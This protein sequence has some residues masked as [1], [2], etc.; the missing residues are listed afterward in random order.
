AGGSHR[1]A[2]G[3]ERGLRRA[4]GP[5]QAARSTGRC[6]TQRRAAHRQGPRARRNRRHRPAAGAFRWRCG[7]I[8]VIRSP[9]TSIPTKVTAMSEAL[10]RITGVTKSYQRG[11]QSVEVLHGVDLSIP[12]GDFIALMGPSGSGKTTLLNLIGGLDTPT[13]GSVEVDG[14]RIDQYSAGQLATWRARNVGFVFQFYN[15]LPV[16]TAQ[17]N[18]E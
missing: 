6:A 14:Q 10:V 15:L 18:V 5:R 9:G 16:L 12:K 11:K 1:R 2:R 13:A 8:Q 7:A 4:R 17:A 3:K